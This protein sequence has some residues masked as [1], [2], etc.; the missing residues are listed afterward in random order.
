MT[1]SS[2]VLFLIDRKQVTTCH[3]MNHLDLFIALNKLANF[4]ALFKIN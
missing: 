2:S 1:Q 4:G 3:A